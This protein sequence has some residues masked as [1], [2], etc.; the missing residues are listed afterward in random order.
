M[1]DRE[2]VADADLH[3][4]ASLY[5]LGALDGDQRV[6]FEEHLRQGCDACAKDVLAFADIANLIGESV[7]AT[8]SPRLRE[9][10]LSRVTSSPQVPGILFEQGGLLI[11]RS[12]ELAWQTMAPG[13]TFKALYVDSDRKY[14]TSLVRMEAGARYPSHHHAAIEELFMLSGDLHVE[15]QVIRAG[16]YCRGDSG[17]VHGETFTDAGC[18]FLMMAS[19]DNQIV[20]NRLV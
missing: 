17:S 11:A 4:L 9:R 10:L 1:N 3:E 6:A 19:Q 14:N 18:L 8:P 13:V 2:H 16:D 15:G 7:V 20:E 12:D 5:A